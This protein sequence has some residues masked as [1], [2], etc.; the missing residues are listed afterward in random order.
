M[1][2]SVLA[3]L[4]LR[5]GQTVAL[6]RLVDEL[7]DNPPATAARTIQAYVSRL[8]RE[9]PSGA[10]ER[11]PGGY[12]VI[13]EPDDLDLKT[14][15]QRA[16]E[17]RAA[18][19]AADYQRS[20][21]LLERALTLWRGPALGGLTS[22]ALRR[23]AVRLEEQRLSVLE[24][25]I[26]ADLGAG[27]HAE[28]V[29]ELTALVSE[30]PYRERLRGQLM[31]ALYR[32]GRPGEALAVYRDARRL[33]VDE[34]GMDPGQELRALEQ[35]I[36]RQDAELVAPALARP[37]GPAGPRAP[38]PGPPVGQAPPRQVRKTVT[39]LFCDVVDSTALG[40]S[41]D[42][43]ALR[44][45]L[46]RYFDRM[47]TIV[48]LHGGTVEKFIG[49]AVM[50][51]FGVP[52]AHE[53]DGVRACRAALEMRESFPELG[54][55]GRIG[56]T[57]G[58]VVTGTEERLATGY[59]VNVAA[60]LQQAAQP[61]D[62]LVG[63][64]TFQLVREAA[65]VEALE[66]LALKGRAKPAGVYRLLAL[67]EA[68]RRHEM[69]F[70]GRKQELA[71]IQNAWHR[72]SVEERC[73]LVTIVGEAG[74]GKSR[75]VAEALATV[76]ACVVEGR[77]LSYGQG[78][79]YWPVVEV[80]KQ[81]EAAPSD[82]GA[83]AAIQSLF[84][85]SKAGA[86][87]EEIAWAFRKL[88]EEQAPLIAVFED[89]QWGEET[90]LDLLEHVALLSSGASILLV[91]TA[92]L[93]LVDRRS[94]WPVTLRL[95]R[96]PADDV[97]ELIGASASSKIRERIARTAGGN[98]LFVSEMLSMAEQ[99]VGEVTV[100][101]TL[102][103]LLA[104][105]LDQLEPGERRVLERAAIE[106]EVF[107][108]G[109]VQA[110][111]PDELQVTPRLAALVRKELILRDRGQL[112]GE[113]GFRFR[114]LLIRDAAYEGL[115]KSERVE[116][117]ERFAA[118]LEKGGRELVEL[119]EILGYHLEQAA[120]YKQ[121]LGNPD[122]TL[123]ERAGARLALVGRRAL[124]RGDDRAAGSLLE[125]ALRLTRPLRLDVHLE[126]DFALTYWE[127]APEQAATIAE[128]AADRARQAG[129]EAGEA[130]ARTSA[131]DHRMSVA[132]DPD[133]EEI[134]TLALTA[135]PLLERVADHTG[136]VHVWIALATVANFRCRFEE[137]AR[138]AE[139]ALRHARLAGQ[140]QPQRI[141]RALAAGLVNGPRPADEA[142]R[143]LDLA[144]P[145]NPPPGLL[146]QRA[147][148]LAMLGRFDEAW[149]L[150]HEANAR[151]RELS[152]T[153]IGYA[154]VADVAEIEG[155][156][157]AAARYTRMFHDWCQE[158]G[159]RAYLSG[160][161]PALG[162]LLCALGQYDEAEPLAQL[163]REVG[164]EQ[165]LVAQMLWRQVKALV[166]ASRGELAEAEQL[167]REAVAIGEETDALNLQGDALRD[168]AEVLHS[169]G[170]IEEGGG[171]LQEALVRYIRK[172]NLAM[173]ARVR[174]RLA[175]LEKQARRRRRVLP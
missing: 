87:A 38:E 103:A 113:D 9:L 71:A 20:A 167:A 145:E 89:I 102:R 82:P 151:E 19:A 163:G 23:E 148:L 49:D 93:D 130:L 97:K 45:L 8:R 83:A 12:A 53:D 65:E 141:S 5:A 48:E 58:V 158:Y 78:I 15:E 46:T 154:F 131:A 54:I 79:T 112:P 6:D 33:L 134:E 2:R 156:Y 153:E 95:K 1:Q 127:S 137:R 60:R 59:P 43:E 136:L 149:P 123:A 135:L 72:A 84:G 100:P 57:S 140:Q 114:H 62:V 173:A 36:L 101:P 117:H 81:L 111:S 7:W 170:R 110:L 13:L 169:A 150:A 55:D 109:A 37:L 56:I 86:T 39:V 164:G 120:R 107:H 128:A 47:K 32:S 129:D 80:I 61:G 91:C 51:V 175:G 27:R 157:E 152:G 161:A 99:A 75:L 121:E 104:A 22:D 41:T 34:L 88:L 18:L 31:T 42:P 70:V 133:T 76:E 159:H 162:R 115:P 124:W 105:R 94:G 30:H 29:G 64:P 17:G 98:P 28:T 155:D 119:D 126:L 4:L 11:R 35:A 143:V 44:A 118:W 166:H 144:S 26:D 96:L 108:R 132:D 138:A 106:G 142:V 160:S 24:D 3:A 122:S 69:R 165:D 168:L 25:R 14:F 125:R 74:V 172:R 85:E 40:V 66:P 77:C 16:N 146:L 52:I 147:R 63:E 171:V 21:M 90:F 68:A 116:L 73:E 50:A 174:T 139:Q 10:I 92:R 67:H